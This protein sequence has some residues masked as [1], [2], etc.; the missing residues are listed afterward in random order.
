MLNIYHIEETVTAMA[1][2]INAP[3]WAVPTFHYSEQSGRPHVEA[4]V[5]GYSYVIAERGEEYS[6]QQTTNFRELLY[7]I[8]KGVSFEMAC[9]W[10]LQNRKEQEDFRRHLFAKQVQIMKE[11]NDEFAEKLQAE[12]EAILTYAPFNDSEDV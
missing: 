4:S 5:L 11:V 9:Q 6:S 8:F 3:I 7:W 12:N 2:R 10:E 1:K